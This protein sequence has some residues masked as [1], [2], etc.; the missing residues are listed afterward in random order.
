[1]SH[2][3]SQLDPSVIIK[4]EFARRRGVKPPR[5]SQ[6]IAAGQISGEA[7]VGNGR[8]A[9]IRESVAVAQLRKRL[10]PLQMA[11]NGIST[12]LQP[13]SDPK[14]PA[15]ADGDILPFGPAPATS[16]PSSPP[17]TDSIE[18]EIKRL[19]RDQLA[20]QEREAQRQEVVNAGRLTDAAAA[21]AAATRE[22]ARLVTMFESSLSNFATAIAAEFKFPQRDVL[23][24]LRREFL[25]F[26]ADTAQSYRTKAAALPEFAEIELSDGTGSA[27]T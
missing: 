17:P 8:N 16:A 21:K 25:K 20:R 2:N 1:M 5:V 24:L 7:I 23:H 6:W 4:A 15:L 18:D 9:R 26:R 14:P 22:T 3:A 27:S 10:D 19:R 13:V 11:G 12:S